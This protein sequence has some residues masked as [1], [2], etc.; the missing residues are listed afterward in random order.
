MR[1]FDSIFDQLAADTKMVG[2][3]GRIASLDHEPAQRRVGDQGGR[4]NGI[5]GFFIIVIVIPSR[6]ALGQVP[7]LTDDRETVRRM[8]QE[9]VRDFFHQCGPIS[10]LAVSGIENYQ[11]PP[12]RQGPRASAAR[13]FICRVTQQ[14]RSRFRRQAFDAVEID[15]EEPCELSQGKRIE[16]LLALDARKV[17]QTESSQFKLFSLFAGRQKIEH[18]GL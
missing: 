2:N 16:W 10:L 3:L 17:P 5:S 15:D 7:L 12:V 11:F 8:T 14:M 13:P 4:A 6:G 18:E 1:N 9:D